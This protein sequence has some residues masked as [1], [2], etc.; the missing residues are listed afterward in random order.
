MRLNAGGQLFVI[1]CGKVFEAISNDLEG[2]GL[3]ISSVNLYCIPDVSSI[4]NKAEDVF[5]AVNSIVDNVFIAVDSNALNHARLELYGRAKFIGLHLNTLIHRT[6]Y[7]SQTA[8]LSD[9][10]WIGP[11]V[12]IAHNCKIGSDT[13][14]NSRARIDSDAEISAHVWIGA[15]SCIGGATRVGQHSCLGDDVIIRNGTKIGKHCILDQ[16]GP[17]EGEIKTGTFMEASYSSSA[18]VVGPGYSFERRSQQ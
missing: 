10:V 11:G 13:L 17:W 7:V 1:G 15:G 14:I 3:E 18:N 4:A 12:T 5:S 2:Y 16:I 9:N 8:R 6:A